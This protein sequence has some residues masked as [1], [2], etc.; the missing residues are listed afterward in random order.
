VSDP[1]DGP[2]CRL[3][4]GAEFEADVPAGYAAHLKPGDLITASP[5]RYELLGFI[6]PQL[7]NLHE[8]LRVTAIDGVSPK[9]TQTGRA[10]V[11]IRDL[12]LILAHVR[13]AGTVAARE[14][15]DRLASAAAAPPAS[16]AGHAVPATGDLSRADDR[17]PARPDAARSPAG[18]ELPARD[19]ETLRRLEPDGFEL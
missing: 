5:G 13:T 11:A 7:A 3:R 4:I 19:T 14:A 16:Q 18:T 8:G 9:Q 17:E 2:V 12:R 1:D 10:S 6:T 15:Y